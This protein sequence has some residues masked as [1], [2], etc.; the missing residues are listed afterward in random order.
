M[1]SSFKKLHRALLHFG[2]VHGLMSVRVTIGTDFLESETSLWM[3]FPM[4]GP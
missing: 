3:R 4:I 2:E 1:L